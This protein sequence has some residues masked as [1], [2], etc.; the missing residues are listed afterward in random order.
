MMNWKSCVLVVLA[1]G[2]LSGC[3]SGSS[4]GTGNVPISVAF[5]L[6]PPN[7]IIFGATGYM[8]ARVYNDDSNSGVTWTCVP[9]GACGSFSPSTTGSTTTPTFTTY[10]AP[11]TNP[12]NGQVVLT[13]TSVKDSTKSASATVVVTGLTIVVTLSTPPPAIVQASSSVFLA[14]NLTNDTT[15]SGVNWSCAPVNAC[16][17]FNPPVTTSGAPTSYT[18]PATV[19]VTTPVNGQVTITATSVADK[20]QNTAAYTLIAGLGSNATF[21]GNY[22]FAIS[23]PTGNRGASAYFGSVNLDGNGNILGGIADLVSP[24]QPD[25]QDKILPTCANPPNANS[26][27]AIDSTGHGTM[28]FCT[29]KG[30]SVSLSFAASSGSHALVIETDGNPASGT[31]DLQNPL[32]TGFD[33]TEISGGYSLTMNGT[34]AANHASQISYGGVFTADGVS[35]VTNGALDINTDGFVAPTEYFAG[36]FELPDANGRGLMVLSSNR[37][38]IYYIVTPKVLRI[39]ESDSQALMSGT[40]YA[41]ASLPSNLL[42]PYV[43]QYSGW[44]SAGRTVAAGQ[45]AV[46]AAGAFSKG[47]SDANSGGAPTTPGVR[48]IDGNYSLVAGTQTGTLNLTD[49]A[50]FSTF[51]MYAVDP[52]VNLLDPNN[53]QGTGGFLLLHTDA[54]INGTGVLIPQTITTPVTYLGNFAFGLN[55]SIVTAQGNNELD[56]AGILS[57]DGYGNF[58]TGLVDYDQNNT[59]GITP[60][61]GIGISLLSQPDPLSLGRIYQTITLPAAGAPSYPFIVPSTTT[62]NVSFYLVNNSQIF[63]IENDNFANTSGYLLQQLLP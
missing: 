24:T 23:A 32:P 39:L 46:S 52:L 9:A 4:S 36:N 16:G 29:A 48:A 61:L 19:P 55:N 58:P 63:V 33:P 43:Y 25:L 27:Y 59:G 8:S 60:N 12:P 41:Q 30:L 7:S 18:A 5:S 49:A 3:G 51:K 26:T 35:S 44:S 47:I 20:T 21:K 22:A 50:G 38:F 40:A 17:S 42:G 56:L 14:A 57:A 31:L 10:T 28:N 54:S 6:A 34:A 2:L 37:T 15:N 62:F 1:L 45:F 13:A 53:L 11:G